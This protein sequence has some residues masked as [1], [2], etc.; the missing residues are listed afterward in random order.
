MGNHDRY[1]TEEDRDQ[2]AAETA[3]ID[4][5]FLDAANM[6]GRMCAIPANLL[7]AGDIVWLAQHEPA[8]ERYLGGHIGNIHTI[9]K[10]DVAELRSMHDKL[11]ARGVLLPALPPTKKRKP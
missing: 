8:R 7:T 11:V 5:L 1:N 9:S 10:D 4:A 3:R 2:E 6:Y